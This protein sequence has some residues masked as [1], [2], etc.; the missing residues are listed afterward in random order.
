MSWALLPN[1]TRTLLN[2]CDCKICLMI[3][4]MTLLLLPVQERVFGLSCECKFENDWL[5]CRSGH[6][7]H[8]MS[9]WYKFKGAH[10]NEIQLL[11]KTHAA[12]KF[13]VKCI[14]SGF[15]LSNVIIS[16]VWY[17]ISRIHCVEWPGNDCDDDD[18]N[19]K[20]WTISLFLFSENKGK[21]QFPN[22]CCK[23]SVLNVVNLNL[24]QAEHWVRVCRSQ[25]T[26]YCQVV[27]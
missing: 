12:V 21:L 23:G 19:C 10:S 17:V 8:I 20:A 24:V 1:T 22:T 6:I 13:M 27:S 25:M 14:T 9:K 3:L 16:I 26:P 5:P 7:S 15:M 18:D 4:R 11:G 2:H